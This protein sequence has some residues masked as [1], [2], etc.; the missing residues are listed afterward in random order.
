MRELNQIEMQEISGAGPIT[1]AATALGAGIGSIIES[2]GVKGAKDAAASLGA[3]IGQVIEAGV[4]ILNSIF[5]G[6]FGRRK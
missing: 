1:D 2:V 3:G 5:G 6:I 4:N